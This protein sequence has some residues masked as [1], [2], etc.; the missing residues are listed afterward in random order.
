MA[1]LREDP[2]KIAGSFIRAVETYEYDGIVVDIDTATLAGAVGVPVVFP[3]DQ[4][5]R[6]H[7]LYL[8]RL[9]DV[10]NLDRS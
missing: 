3:E 2:E 8:E 1:E 5:A 10:K 7:G 9:A 4:P 6:A